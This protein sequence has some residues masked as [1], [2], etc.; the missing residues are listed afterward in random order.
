[1]VKKKSKINF[2]GSEKDIQKLTTNLSTI[3]F[4]DCDGEQCEEDD[5]KCF[6][7]E[8]HSTRS[9]RFFLLFDGG[10]LVDPISENLFGR[11]RRTFSFKSVSQKCFNNFMNYAKTKKQSYFNI[12]RRNIND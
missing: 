6:M 8:I 3:N 9:S 1:M 5:P 12:A 10:S 11:K 4:Y 7:K 2:I